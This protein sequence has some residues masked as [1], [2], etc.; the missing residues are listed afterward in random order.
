MAENTPRLSF[1]CDYEEGAHP[2][3]LKRLADTNFLKEPGYGYDEF[4][5]AAK[6]KIRE[7]CGA[8]NAGVYF[9]IGGT[10]TNATVI[11]AVLRGYQGVVAAQT[12]HVAVHEAGAIEFGGHK[13]LTVPQERGKVSAAVLNQSLLD[14]ENDGS[15]EHMVHPGLVYISQPTEY[16]TLYSK[17]ELEAIRAVCD[18]H[19]L[20][21]F[22]DGTRLAYALASP[23]N[24]V[25]IKDLARLSDVFYIGGTKNG[26]L[27]GE[28]LVIVNPEDFIP[29]FFTTIKQHGALLAKGRVAGIQFETLFTDGLY[30]K[31]GIPAIRNAR[32]IQDAL[33]ASGY[34]LLFESP[35]NQIFVVLENTQMAELAK[36]V[37]F[38]FW[39]KKDETHTVVRFATSWATR[40]EDADELVRLL[41]DMRLA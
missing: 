26:A 14:I 31:I 35:T 21:L 28:A 8:P 41:K 39:E 20:P 9:L 4:S 29:H 1:T 23:E 17:S 33:R 11:D 7:A 12:G 10:Q 24:D 34:E 38:S 3:I 27:F 22:I 19:K 5:L 15:Y 25:S 37:A 40:D 13:V 2:A 30:E 18:E 32:K 6:D 36:S 16:G